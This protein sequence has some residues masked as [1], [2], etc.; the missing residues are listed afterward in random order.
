MQSR[1]DNPL[2]DYP[3]GQRLAI[4]KL[5]EVLMDLINEH[6][7]SQTEE[8]SSPFFDEN[9]KALPEVRSVGKSLNEMGGYELM[10]ECCRAMPQEHRRTLEFA[11]TG[12]GSWLP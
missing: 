6:E 11:W 1:T 8:G 7:R 5:L 4:V 12:I 10:L 2:M 9:S 3:V